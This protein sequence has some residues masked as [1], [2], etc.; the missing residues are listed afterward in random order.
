MATDQSNSNTFPWKLFVLLGGLIA[1]SIPLHHVVL[2]NSSLRASYHPY[3]VEIPSPREVQGQVSWLNVNGA[4]H[5][6]SYLYPALDLDGELVWLS[7]GMVVR[8]EFFAGLENGDQLTIVY[9]ETQPRTSYIR[10]EILASPPGI[11][12]ERIVLPII[13]V[14][15]GLGL[16]IWGILSTTRNARFAP[17]EIS[18]G[19][20]PGN[21]EPGI[22]AQIRWHRWTPLLI[23]GWASALAFGELFLLGQSLSVLEIRLF[24]ILLWTMNLP[25]ALLMGVFRLS[26]NAWPGFVISAA[27][28]FGIGA[29]LGWRMKNRWIAVSAWI[30]LAVILMICGF[31][32]L[33]SSMGSMEP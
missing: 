9:S 25:G 4:D 8:E 1:V 3:E 15:N 13:L 30:I 16:L 32:L 17:V 21:D 26:A 33:V 29:L 19:N 2:L 7:G 20:V 24:G 27:I 14:L 11:P 5:E 18:R 22:P 6:V 31:F 28:W 23:G 10:N 12:Q